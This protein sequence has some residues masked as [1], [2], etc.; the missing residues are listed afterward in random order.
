M[1]PYPDNWHDEVDSVFYCSN[2]DGLITNNA[3]V[4]HGLNIGLRYATK[5]YLSLAVGF[6]RHNR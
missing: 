2:A 3:F 1:Y 4:P 6:I 5:S